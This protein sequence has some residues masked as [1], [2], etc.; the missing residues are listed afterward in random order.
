VRSTLAPI[1]FSLRICVAVREKGTGG[2]NAMCIGTSRMGSVVTGSQPVPRYRHRADFATALFVG[3]SVAIGAISPTSSASALSQGPNYPVSVVND[4]SV[5]PHPWDDPQNATASDGFFFPNDPE[6]YASLNVFTSEFVAH[7]QYLKATGFGF[8]IPNSGVI[9]GIEMGLER[10][11]IA[12]F[13]VNINVVKGGAF[14]AVNKAHQADEWF[15]G[16]LVVTYGGNGD[17]WGE[18]WTAADINSPD[19]GVAISA[20]AI[21]GFGFV[22]SIS[23][24]VFYSVL[25]CGNGQIDAGE[26]CDDGNTVNGDC[27]SSTC[28]YEPA[29]YPCADSTVCNGD[30]TCDGA[31]VCQPG[32]APDCDDDDLCTKDSCNP[33]GGCVN[34]GS[35]VGG[36]RTALKSILLLKDK[37]DDN[38]DKLVWK[39]VKGQSTVQDDFGV[40]TGTTQYA[41]CIHAGAP[42]TLLA[43]YNVPADAMKWSVIGTKGYKYTDPSGGA[44]GIT[45]VLLKGGAPNKAKC[46]VKG[47]GSTLA[48]FDLTTL[49]DPVTVQLVNS[50]NST[51]FESTFQ[52]AD[53]ITSNDAAQF[54]AKAQ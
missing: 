50:A 18:T 34:D 49:V 10:G 5:G 1:E 46:L 47:K 2:D 53:F 11:G 52:Q 39:W 31:G 23:M 40:P 6:H 45:K 43:S 3:L 41:L 9:E 17:L 7:S 14:G 44:A 25:G 24:T 30:E 4:P 16:D 12:C 28:Q 42:S 33:V 29:G 51:C 8:A 15:P 20:T 21:D 22:D 27:C 38:T 36:C 35:L 37:A 54:K 13:D 19:F 26:D 32:T 48:D